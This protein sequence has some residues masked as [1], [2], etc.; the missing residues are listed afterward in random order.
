MEAGI[1]GRQ[2]ILEA[3]RRLNQQIRAGQLELAQEKLKGLSDEERLSR[4]QLEIRRQIG[5]IRID[6]LD[7]IAGSVAKANEAAQAARSLLSQ[8]PSD[9]VK[10]GEEVIATE[11]ELADLR[12][13]IIKKIQS[14]QESVSREQVLRAGEEGEQRARALLNEAD[15][16]HKAAVQAA[17]DITDLTERVTEQK[18]RLASAIRDLGGTVGTALDE[19]VGKVVT[20]LDE[21]FGADAQEEAKRYL[22]ILSKIATEFGKVAGKTAPTLPT[23]PG[24]GA[25]FG[26]R[27]PG[28][29]GGDRLPFI[30]ES[31]ESVLRKEVTRALEMR[32]GD[33]VIGRMNQMKLQEI[34]QGGG[35]GRGGDTFVFAPQFSPD[36]LRT[37]HDLGVSEEVV[38]KILVKFNQRWERQIYKQRGRRL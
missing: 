5:S 23:G 7:D 31:G 38:D 1:Q 30:L 24:Q 32:F 26:I 3:E 9:T 14:A 36:D 18:D 16:A 35:R 37:L 25:E 29:G 2:K 4:V 6:N 12:L 13:S 19:S 15:I 11:E 34:F 22:D 8:L 20:K 21:A 17:G 27:I 33:D 10:S 28:Y